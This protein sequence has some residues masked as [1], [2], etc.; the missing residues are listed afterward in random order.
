MNYGYFDDQNRE[1]VIT[2]PDTPASWCNYLGTLDYGGIIT[3]NAGGYSF[4]KS[5]ADGRILRYRFNSIPQD[6][7][8]RYIYLRDREN[9]D[10]WSA[11]WQ[12]VAKDLKK[13]ASVCRHGTGY[14]IITSDYDRIKTETVFY[15]PLAK[16]C[17]VWAFK[18]KNNDSRERKLTIFNYAEL[19]NDNN[20]NQDLVNLQYTL[21][22]TRTYFKEN[23]LL[24]T[25]NENRNDGNAVYR[26]AGLAGA[27]VTGYDGG[28]E[29]FIGPYR[30]YAN[31]AAVVN[32]KCGNSLNYT[33]NSC[34]ALQTDLELAPGEEKEMF[35]IVGYGDETT[36]RRVIKEYEDPEKARIEIEQIKR[37]WHGRLD[38]F[39]VNT[40]DP[41]FNRMVNIWNAYQCFITFFWSRAASL[42][43]CGLRNGLGFRDTVQ[44]IQGIMHLEAES[45]KERLSYMLS[46]QVS[47][48]GGM[49]LVRFDHQPGKAVPPKPEEY[50]C[51]DALWL[52]QT[53]PQ[54][55]KESGD[56]GYLDEVTP[57]ADQGEGT[58]YDH[59]KRALNFSL[60][61]LGKHG[62]VYGLEADWNDCIRLEEEGESVFASLQ[63][64]LALGVFVDLAR[65]K[66]NMEDVLWAGENWS[67][68]GE[69]L[70]KHAWEGDRFVRAFTGDGYVVGSKQNEE[71]GLWLNPQCYAVISGAA[72][73]EQGQKAMDKVYEEL[74]TEHGILLMNP[75][76]KK[77][78]L[79]V[80]RMILYL[81]GIKENA[82]I[83]SQPQ[84]WAILAETMLGRGDRAYQYYCNCNPA[85]M[86]D[87][88]EIRVAE[89]YV[90]CQFTEGKESPFHGRAHVHWLTGAAST[91]QVA[92]VEGILGVKPDY[93]GLRIN[94]CIPA[95]WK[96]F[97]MER[98]FRGKSL[99]IRVD[100]SAGVQKGV[101]R[102]I[103][104][105]EAMIDDLIPE[106][107][108][109]PE[110]EVEVLM[111]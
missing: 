58:V 34:G 61:R 82:G 104:N 92:A 37:L 103:L 48:G 63:L 21:F 88:A 56:W 14:T 106:A 59:L 42:T 12:P 31:P 11:S 76:F 20:E 29:G 27:K 98:V 109:G 86:N 108:M 52:F 40:P 30:S 84:G 26:Y 85:K 25:V 64:Y 102:I 83:F 99:R 73:G 5:G 13:Y 16:K 36:A 75:A 41:D 18:I 43:Y 79:P 3:N 94:P 93:E 72:L 68:L 110:N 96:E 65:R 53:V 78:G 2:R 15:I 89:P 4:V 67:R 22:I 97:T 100:N 24:Q 74:N 9:G 1:Y 45:A 23:L 87:R 47:N 8:G 80:F 105:G 46:G 38:K 50:R 10:Y 35:F 111:G 39:Q 32:G 57:Y 81:P 60:E 95:W 66:G 55:L 70:Y 49:P 91:I 69:N 17:E 62:L 7:P 44:D 101:R 77:R 19:S 6:Q 54:Y 107:K 71:A 51:D 90:H 33:G 28:R